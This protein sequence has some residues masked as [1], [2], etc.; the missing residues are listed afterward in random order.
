MEITLL[1]VTGL[2]ILGIDL[3]FNKFISNISKY[4]KYFTFKYVSQEKNQFETMEE[5]LENGKDV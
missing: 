4:N 5:Y 2:E 1:L 3:I